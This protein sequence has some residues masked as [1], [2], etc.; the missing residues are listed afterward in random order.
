MT[1]NHS[2]A[3][4]AMMQAEAREALLASEEAE[5][6]EKLRLINKAFPFAVQGSGQGLLI[7]WTGA[8]WSI[9]DTAGF[10]TRLEKDDVVT[11][12]VMIGM[13]AGKKGSVRE[14]VTGEERKAKI[15]ALSDVKPNE[16][17]NM[18]SS[19]LTL[20]NLGLKR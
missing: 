18:K 2:A 19:K 8:D 12:L 10:I 1:P 9:S 16:L 13:E 5:G 14:I 15:V 17:H 6:L 3:E 20:A 4:I 11:M 7:A